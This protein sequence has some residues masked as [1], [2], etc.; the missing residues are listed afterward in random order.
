MVK[1]HL[2]VVAPVLGL[3]VMLAN[4][5]LA[6]DLTVAS[7]TADCSGFTL[8]VTAINLNVGA[9]FTIDFTFTL[10]PTSGPAITVPGTIS[11]TAAAGTETHTASGPWPGAPLSSNFT[12]TGSATLIQSGSTLPITI[13]GATSV[14][15]SCGGTT[16]SSTSS[17]TTTT[18]PPLCLSRT[19]GFWGNHPFL[20]TGGD[21]RS[22]DLLPLDVCGTPLTSVAAFS[23]VS[24][25]EAICS[26]GTDGKILGQQETQLIRQCTAALLNVKT[27]E[28]LG[29]SCEGAFLGL[30][31][32]LDACCDGDSV[33][34][35]ATVPGFT[36]GSCS[37]QV[38]A[39]NSTESNTITFPFDTGPADSSIC[40]ASKGN[41]VVV[42]PTP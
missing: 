8:S 27:T 5:A 42:S 12:V 13:N 18:A 31:D 3:L 22:L 20:I 23:T 33:C 16:T 2:G 39:F 38:D 4:P 14:V 10:T 34:T 32:L 7:A 1:K 35:G 29:G 36:V 21:P 41:G 28:V 17:T 37:D 6:N 26:V 15:L 24:T 30:T 40:R 9:S 19:P 11:F 25:T